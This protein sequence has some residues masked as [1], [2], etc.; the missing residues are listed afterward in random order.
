MGKEQKPKQPT[1][2]TKF[3]RI[4]NVP[5]TADMKAFNGAWM[6]NIDP[7]LIGVDNSQ[8]LI[9]MRYTEGGIEGVN[10]YTAF[11]ATAIDTYVKLLSGIHFRT[12]RVNDSYLL[13]HAV[14]SSGNGVVKVSKSAIGGSGSFESTAVW[15]DTSADLTGRFAIGPSGVVAYCNQ[16]ESA[17]WGGDE[18]SIADVFTLANADP[19]NS[20]A[21]PIERSEKIINRLLTDYLVMDTSDRSTIL[22]MSQAPLKGIKLYVDPANAN[23]NAANTDDLVVKYWDGSSM[24]A[25]PATLTDGTAKLTQTGTISFGTTLDLAVPKHYEERY[26][27][28]YTVDITATSG[29][30]SANIYQITVDAPMQAPTNIWDGVYRQPIQVQRYDSSSGS[31]QDF[32][33]HVSESSTETVPVGLYL[34][35]LTTT[36][37]I[38]LMFDEPMSAIRFTMLGSLINT[39]NAQIDEVKY[40]DGD[41]FSTSTFVDGTLDDAGDSS[42]A[43][44]GL[45]SWEV[46][47]DEEKT[48]L[49]GTLGYAYRL[50]VDA[51]L[52]GSAN[53]DVVV[54][55][56]TGVPAKKSVPV[57]KF[58][59]QYKN[60]LMLC[61]YVEGNEGNRIDFS[62]DNAPNVFNGED[63]S[64]N[65]FQSIFV[66]SVE[67]V[68]AATQLYNRFGSNIFSTFIILKNN[69]VWLMTGDSPLDYEL[70]PIS[71]RIGCPAPQTLTTAE[72]GF[73]I[74]ENVER[75]VSMWVSHQGPI[76]FDGAI[77]HPLT[78]IE[79]YFDPN[80]S[81]S[82]NFTYLHTAQSWFDSTYNEW[83]ILLPTGNSTTLNTWLVYDMRRRKWY[84]KDTNLGD[85]IVC[86]INA[87]A[88]SGDQYV[89]GGSLVGT[90]YQLE[91][92]T[93]WG[94]SPITYTITTGDFFP[95]GNQWD[96]TLLRRLKLVTERLTE[97]G[98]TVDIY[99]YKNT[100]RDEGLSVEWE[101]DDILWTSVTATMTNSGEAG[102]EWASP[103]TITLAMDADVG[104]N[105]LVR[106]TKALN[107]TAWAHAL[108]FQFTS[109]ETS[110][111]TPI[112]WGY[113]WLF[114]RRDHQ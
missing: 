108:S 106:T 30:S 74:G 82:V 6:P 78:G 113:E 28:A 41:S 111:Y 9:N 10:G 29:T 95:S 27:Y 34:G 104:N 91:S 51:T 58:P 66:G 90:L 69:E 50:K 73:A 36:D 105:R 89:Y 7:A 59:S 114:V 110:K 94:G 3:P 102:V 71:F 42:F 61:G 46:P 45:I 39:D 44:S 64:M 101:D 33:L 57:F 31:F 72:V 54:D 112:M 65:G 43:S 62:A 76:M 70:F 80:E 38:T 86:G 26:L 93:S 35:Q 12:N 63:S 48:T 83:N 97:S 84:Q 23:T 49:F 67:E 103:P 40:W 53:D 107:E 18:A 92:G 32:T 77:L 81:D 60:K 85:V 96:I 52:F 98:A 100:N 25:V 24:T 5:I 16:E 4:E 55:I 75:N 15:T 19:D 37:N 17:I 8:S 22:V 11:N 88:T 20:G 68:T 109:D 56:I 14:D 87:I 21:Y 79:N 13:V 1:I 99:Y 47:S 2:E